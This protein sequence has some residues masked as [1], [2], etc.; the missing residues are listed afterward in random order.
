VKAPFH[1]TEA[2]ARREMFPGSNSRVRPTQRGDRTALSHLL[3]L[4]AWKH[5]HLGWTDPLALLEEQ[6]ALVLEEYR[7]LLAALACPPEPEAI[8][9]LRLFAASNRTTPDAAWRLLWPPAEE[10]AR[11]MNVSQ[12]A[13]LVLDDWLREPAA[14]S[15]FEQTHEVI[16]LKWM[17]RP[18]PSAGTIPG[19]IRRMESSD[20]SIV[21]ELDREAFDPIWRNSRRALQEAF[22]G[23]SYATVVESH[24]QVLGYQISTVS[25]LGAHIARLAVS[26]DRQGQGLGGALVRDTVERFTASGVPQ[27]TVNTQSDNLRSLDLYHR[28]GF[29]PTGQRFPVLEKEL[30]E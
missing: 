11:R 18:L 14:K 30:G 1:P 22:S 7:T 27:V 3:S 2:A 15:G 13:I 20:L 23:S 16:F 21:H 5:L 4:A 24:D 28:L 8:C 6:P 29:R 9:W 26:P 25:P 10:Q 12:A 19:R 17:D